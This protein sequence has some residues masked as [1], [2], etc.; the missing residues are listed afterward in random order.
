MNRKGVTS[1]IIGE[2][3][4]G[5]DRRKEKRKGNSLYTTLIKIGRMYE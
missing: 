3:Q 4:C 5:I 2:D 1:P